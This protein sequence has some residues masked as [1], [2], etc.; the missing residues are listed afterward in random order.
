VP[1]PARRAV[2]VAQ[3]GDDD[4]RLPH[5]RVD[6]RR[7]LVFRRARADLPTSEI[8]LGPLVILLCVKSLRLRLHG[9]C[10]QTVGGLS[11]W[12]QADAQRHVPPEQVHLTPIRPGH[13]PRSTRALALRPALEPRGLDLQRVHNL[14]RLRRQFPLGCAFVGS[15]V[16]RWERPTQPQVAHLCESV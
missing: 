6:G 14:F 9:N 2:G 7:A 3:R 8:P 5:D 10:T 15:R 13:Q 12:Y 11:S 16:R 1:A 4:A